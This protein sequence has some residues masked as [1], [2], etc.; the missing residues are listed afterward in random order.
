MAIKKRKQRK[1][2]N[3]KKDVKPKSKQTKKQNEKVVGSNSGLWELKLKRTQE[4][5]TR[6]QKAYYD[7][8][9]QNEHLKSL[10]NRSQMLQ[11]QTAGFWEKKCGAKNERI[12]VLEAEFQRQREH[13]FEEECAWEIRKRQCLEEFQIEIA[14]H[15]RA[16]ASWRK[17]ISNMRKQLNITKVEHKESLRKKEEE[18]SLLVKQ[19][20]ETEM[21]LKTHFENEIN[22]LKHTQEK[23][24]VQLKHELKHVYKRKNSLTDKLRDAQ[25]EIEELRKLDQSLSKEKL[26]LAVDKKILTSTLKETIEEKAAQEKKLNVVS[27]KIPPL[28][29]ALKNIEEESREKEKMNQFTIQASKV[30]LEKLQRVIANQ[31]REMH[32]LKQLARTVVEK[33]KEVEVF[34][35][36]ALDHVRQEIANDRHRFKAEAYQDYR[37]KFREGMVRKTKLP[38][39]RTFN[40]NPN[41]TNSVYSDMKAAEKWPHPPG[42]EVFM[43][44]LTWEQKEKVLTL[45]FA[46]MNGYAGGAI[47]KKLDLCESCT[48]Q[49]GLLTPKPPSQ[50]FSSRNVR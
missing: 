8:A 21:N 3:T 11:F 34:F 44:D 30:E 37:Q 5:V 15:K 47:N 14:K 45:L 29:Q 22:L 20:A 42:K 36:E 18:F 4:E 10:L 24:M 41:S 25:A 33:R 12:R 27:A 49:N 9:S 23:A 35:H 38:P 6:Y 32:R 26:L 2:R 46:K 40:Q 28:E 1:A 39:I 16:E 31:E 17:K 43:S 13:A 50:R 19:A 7:M 48:K